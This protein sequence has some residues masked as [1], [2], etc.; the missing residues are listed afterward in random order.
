MRRPS[1][2]AEFRS[3]AAMALGGATRSNDAK[4]NPQIVNALLK[5]ALDG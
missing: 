5:K 4:A 3:A 1:E 2:D